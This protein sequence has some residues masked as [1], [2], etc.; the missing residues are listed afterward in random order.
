MGALHDGHLALVRAAKRV[1][2]SVVVVSIFVNPLQF[3]ADED[4]DAYPRTLDDD[5]A[6]LRGEGVEIA[7]TPSGRGD[8]SG[9]PAHHRA[10]RPAG[11][12][13][14]GWL[15]AHA[16]R[17]HAHRGVQAAADRASGPGV[18]RREGLSAAGADPADGRRPERRRRGGR[19]CRPCGKP[20]GWRC[21]RATATS[22][23]RSAN[24]PGALGGADGRGA[25]RARRRAGRAGRGP[26]RAR[27]GARDRRRLPGSARRRPRPG[28]ADR[29][30]RLLVAARLGTTRLLD[31]VAIEIGSERTSPAPVGPDGYRDTFESPWRN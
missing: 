25:R 14:R 27:C 6:L 29:P 10:S 9:R 8:V 16:F 7:F 30:G 11:S 23:R 20:T 12:R 17:R 5:L 24:W 28:Q 21:R 18:L 4:L 3:G 19:R 22:T 1:P 26:R 13:A 31:N 15:P 2:G